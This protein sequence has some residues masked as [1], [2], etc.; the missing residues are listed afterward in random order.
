MLTRSL[1]LLILV[2]LIALFCP[3]VSAGSPGKCLSYA[4]SNQAGEKDRAAASE[5]VSEKAV[6]MVASFLA[7][8]KTHHLLALSDVPKTVLEDE[9]SG[10]SWASRGLKQ[11]DMLAFAVMEGDANGDGIED[12]VAIIVRGDN[13]HKLYSLI[14]FNGRKGGGYIP[15]PFWVV[16]DS[17]HFIGNVYVVSP[18]IYVI[19]DDLGSGGWVPDEDYS[20]NGSGYEEGYL[21]A[22]EHVCSSSG[23]KIFSLPRPTSRVV[24]EFKAEGAELLI[25]S[26]A[27]RKVGG[28]RWYKVQV[29]RNNRRT[30][31][32]GFVSG[33][34]LNPD[35]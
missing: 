19:Y 32:V 5:Q 15:T 34:R 29:L 7:T 3:A 24:K 20:W 10:K 2:A 35:C 14:C 1:R 23:N 4:G 17:S 25:L 9:R 13:D 16:K 12:V 26:A 18:A 27:P 21:L 22:G 33:V 31:I 11:A 28:V 30:P 8:N 6:S